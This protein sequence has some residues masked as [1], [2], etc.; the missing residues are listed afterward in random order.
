MTHVVDSPMVESRS[1]EGGTPDA[2]ASLVQLDVTA[3]GGREEQRRVQA[4]GNCLERI[5]DALTE[6]HAPSLP[7]VFTHCF[8]RPC[9]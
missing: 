9:V 7:Q 1:Y 2:V 3:P 6:R 5:Q 8:K 4:R